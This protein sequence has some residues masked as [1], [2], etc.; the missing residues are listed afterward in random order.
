MTKGNIGIDQLRKTSSGKSNSK[1]VLCPKD[2]LHADL[3]I[4]MT[5]GDDW[6]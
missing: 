5:C 4:A 2:V 6:R 3:C 1:A